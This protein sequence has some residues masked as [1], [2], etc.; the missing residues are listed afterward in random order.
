MIGSS[1]RV[2]PLS[3]TRRAS[4][5]RLHRR[6]AGRFRGPNAWELENNVRRAEE[7][8]Y[9]VAHLGAMPLVTHSLGRYFDGTLTDQFWLDGTLE[10]MR[11]CDALMMIPGWETSQGANTERALALEM[12]IPVFSDIDELERWLIKESGR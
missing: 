6:I 12:G 3:M 1:S 9:A 7:V 5:S 4:E 10:L 8:A 2:V 11:R